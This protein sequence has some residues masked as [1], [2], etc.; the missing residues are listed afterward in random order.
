M[1]RLLLLALMV[2]PFALSAAPQ[3]DSFSRAAGTGQS[4]NESGSIWYS[5]IFL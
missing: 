2:S 5:P 3:A 4:R 1:K